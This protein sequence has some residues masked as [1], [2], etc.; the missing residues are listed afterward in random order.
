MDILTKKQE[1]FLD[2]AGLF[3]LLISLACL[4]QHFYF[5]IT[6]W[7]TISII[8]VYLLSVVSFFMLM[9]KHD[10]API[11]LLISTVLIF[12]TLLLLMLSLA[13]SPVLLLLLVYSLIIVILTYV[14]GYP[15]LL[16]KRKL[17]IKAEE[18]KWK[19]II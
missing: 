15:A 14:N 12:C 3:G 8:G 11:F 6:G 17:A 18:D 4:F 10:K 9:R 2:N 19:N 7:I 5:M 1:N 16:T 13:F